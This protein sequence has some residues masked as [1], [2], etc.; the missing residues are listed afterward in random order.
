MPEDETAAT[1]L[2]AE[3]LKAE[4][5]F[6]SAFD[7]FDR[8]GI[9]VGIFRLVDLVKP[10]SGLTRAGLECPTGSPAWLPSQRTM[11]WVVMVTIADVVEAVAFVDKT[12]ASTAKVGQCF[13]PFESDWWWIALAFAL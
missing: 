9:V 3:I 8:L 10:P 1:L 5:P 4:P 6:A 7:I 11:L 12:L 13:S 2:L